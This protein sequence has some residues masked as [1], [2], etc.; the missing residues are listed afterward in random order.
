MGLPFEIKLNTNTVLVLVFNFI[1]WAFVFKSIF[2]DFFKHKKQK[3]VEHQVSQAT[4][5]QITF[6]APTATIEVQ[7]APVVA[8]D[9]PA[10]SPENIPVPGIETK[11]QSAA[12]ATSSHPLI[13]KTRP[14]DFGNYNESFEA[15]DKD[16]QKM[17]F[18]LEKEIKNFVEKD[19]TADTTLPRDPTR[20]MIRELCKDFGVTLKRPLEGDQTNWVKQLDDVFE[21]LK[22]SENILIIT[23]LDGVCA[24]TKARQANIETF[25]PGV[26][27][28][29][30]FRREIFYSRGEI[31]RLFDKLTKKYDRTIMLARPEEIWSFG[32]HADLKFLDLDVVRNE[33]AGPTV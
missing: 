27:V 14:T 21:G 11:V 19:K 29:T 33:S 7:A 17:T 10:S 15:I 23:N 31:T 32:V 28:L 26:D 5:P 8:I 18:R 2:Q 3:K 13:P 9:S 20:V 4:E 24:A 22:P 12:E 16:I 30:N 1:L 6:N 25:Y